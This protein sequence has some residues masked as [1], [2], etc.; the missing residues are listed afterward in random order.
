MTRKRAAHKKSRGPLFKKVNGSLIMPLSP[1][2]VAT[3]IGAL[4]A[5][6]IAF[7]ALGS[8]GQAAILAPVRA[9]ARAKAFTDSL[10][11]ADKAEAD[12][13]KFERLIREQQETN[14]TLS[15]LV[16]ALVAPPEKRTVVLSLLQAKYT[17]SVGK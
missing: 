14:E 6:A 3:T 5:G 7:I 15:D 9:E 16:V 10:K 11:F 4:S 2:R 1:L 13:S 12:S 17:I 8:W